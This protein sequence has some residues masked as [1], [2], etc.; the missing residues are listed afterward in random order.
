MGGVGPLSS[1]NVGRVAWLALWVAVIADSRSVAIGYATTRRPRAWQ[2][3]RTRRLGFSIVELIVVVAILGIVASIAVRRIG[4]MAQKSRIAVLQMTVRNVSGVVHE[5]HGV[6][7]EYPPEILAEWFTTGV[8]PA[9]PYFAGTPTVEVVNAPGVTEPT[10]KR[11]GGGNDPYW[12]NTA[13]GYFRA[14]VGATVSA[15]VFAT[16]NLGGA[17]AGAGVV[18]GGGGRAGGG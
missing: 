16:V 15:E 18:S 8:L 14:R 13:N 9:N 1:E 7:G 5:Y 17:R 10:A 11:V 6:H 2:R 4:G 3:R 12:Y